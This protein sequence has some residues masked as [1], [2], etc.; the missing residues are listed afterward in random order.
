MSSQVVASPEVPIKD[1]KLISATQSNSANVITPS[2]ILPA[3]HDTP[4][5]VSPDIANEKAKIINLSQTTT[6]SGKKSMFL[7]H[8]NGC[9]Q[10]VVY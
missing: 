2:I 5:S 3:G 10:D 1:E 7:T 8:L 4:V 9:N 6:V